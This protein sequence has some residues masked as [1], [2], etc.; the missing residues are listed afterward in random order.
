MPTINRGHMHKRSANAKKL[1]LTRLKGM[2]RR[3]IE[4]QSGRA[5]ERARVNARK[6][7]ENLFFGH[8]LA[9]PHRLS[10][11]NGT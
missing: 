2:G 3:T 11:E 6:E 7:Q 9:W 8:L 5:A 1:T 10:D 4:R